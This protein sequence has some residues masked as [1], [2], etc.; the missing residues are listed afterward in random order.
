MATTNNHIMLQEFGIIF[1]PLTFLPGI[2]LLIQSTSRRYIELIRQLQSIIDRYVTY[3]VDFNR[4]QNQRLRMFKWALS[5]LYISAIM[6][7]LGSLLAGL[8]I[9][10]PNTSNVFLFG[11]LILAVLM[12]AIALGILVRESFVSATLI[13]E[14]LKK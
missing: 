1:A 14:Q 6:I 12:A 4:C 2:G 5:S 10:Y 7:L 11:F 9:Q 3:S 13:D 8:S